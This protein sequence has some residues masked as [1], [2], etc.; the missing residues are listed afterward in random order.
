MGMAQGRDDL[1]GQGRVDAGGE[2]VG[3]GDSAD[4]MA[5]GMA[6]EA[7]AAADAEGV[8]KVGGARRDLDP[9]GRTWRLLLSKW[10]GG[11]VKTQAFLPMP[12]PGLAFCER[13]QPKMVRGA[14]G[15][16]TIEKALKGDGIH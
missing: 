14:Y 5:Q 9:V 3:G 1:G 10:G 16:I 7:A 2:V 4:D 13:G 6:D 8:G 11:P 12:S 15:T